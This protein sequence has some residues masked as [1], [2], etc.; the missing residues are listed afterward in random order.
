MIISEPDIDRRPL[1]ACAASLFVYFVRVRF[2]CWEMMHPYFSVGPPRQRRSTRFLSRRAGSSGIS[3]R[4]FSLVKK[5]LHRHRASFEPQRVS[6]VH[7]RGA[8]RA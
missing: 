2:S 5:T 8:A 6:S 1:S 3:W 7:K 4:I